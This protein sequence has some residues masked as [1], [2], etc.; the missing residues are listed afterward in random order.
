MPAARKVWQQ[1]FY[2]EHAA[3]ARRLFIRRASLRSIGRSV[4]LWRV[5]M[6]DTVSRL[7]TTFS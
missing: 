7:E 6:D 4:N 5:S 3:L 2:G 1:M